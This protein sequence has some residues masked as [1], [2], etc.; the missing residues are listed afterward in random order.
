[1]AGVLLPS[2]YRNG[3][4]MLVLGLVVLGGAVAAGCYFGHHVRT[5]FEGPTQV[6]LED[7]AKL[8]DPQQ[9]PSTWVDVKFDKMVKSSVVVEKRP[10]NGGISHVAEEFLI[11]EAGDRWM[12]AAV[13]RGFKG[14]EVSGRIWRRDDKAARSAVAKITI[15]LESTHQGKL[16]PFEFDASVDY[17]VQWKTVGG[18]ILFFTAAGILFSCLGAGAI[19]KSYRPPNPADYG[20]DPANYAGLVVETPAD[21]KAAVAQFI[22]DAGLTPDDDQ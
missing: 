12:I 19:R 9:L 13:P 5:A 21:A 2:V 18:V 10:T 11:F 14:S 15:E 20:L 4:F 3:L 6:Q 8:E 7:I 22:H 17:G 16:F 1:M